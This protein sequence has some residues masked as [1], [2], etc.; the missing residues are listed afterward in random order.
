MPRNYCAIYSVPVVYKTWNFGSHTFL[1]CSKQWFN[2]LFSREPPDERAIVYIC[3]YKL[4]YIWIL[5]M[6][7]IWLSSL[8]ISPKYPAI[9]D[10]TAFKC[11]LQL[12]FSSTITPRNLG[13]DFCLIKKLF[14]NNGRGSSSFL[15]RENVM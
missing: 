11:V 10:C 7:G 13:S 14:N 8:Y 5:T 6:T 4:W 3:Q 9:S 15:E 1:L 2:N 12:K